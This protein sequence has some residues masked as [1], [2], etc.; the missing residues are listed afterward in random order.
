MSEREPLRPRRIVRDPRILGG[1]PFVEGTR[2]SVEQILGLIANGMSVE[3][4]LR[5][6][7]ILTEADVRAVF[8]YARKAAT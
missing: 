1:E 2:M 3:D 7:P 5:S 4:L 6:C 8:D